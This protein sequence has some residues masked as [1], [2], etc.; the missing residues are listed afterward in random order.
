MATNRASGDLV[1]IIEKHSRDISR[2]KGRLT[3]LDL[4][5]GGLTGLGGDDH[6]QYLNVARHDADDHSG[7]DYLPLSGGVLSGKLTVN[8]EIQYD[9]ASGYNGHLGYSDGNNYISHD[10]GG[11]TRFRNSSGSEKVRVD[12]SGLY[13]P[14]GR[15]DITGGYIDMGGGEIY[16]SG[17]S[18]HYINFNSNYIGIWNGNWALL[19]YNGRTEVRQNLD[20]T[21]FRFYGDTDTSITRPTSNHMDFNAAGLRMRVGA[22]SPTVH[23]KAPYASGQSILHLDI[24]RAWNFLQRGT[25]A[26][27]DLEL[28]SETNKG[29]YIGDQS[30]GVIASF[31]Y[32]EVK[33]QGRD[34]T[35]NSGLA[36]WRNNGF[37]GD[38]FLALSS[39]IQYKANPQDL[40]YAELAETFLD[41]RLADWNSTLPKD[42]P[43]RRYAGWIAEEVQPKLPHYAADPDENGYVSGIGDMTVPMA[44][45]LHYHED[46]I[47]MLETKVAELERKLRSI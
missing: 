30:N 31:H 38:E 4:D 46:R 11:Y 24:E 44:A 5:H 47:Q 1:E 45:T 8:A 39:S 41:I 27:T 16:Y 3:G 40:D 2:L 32:G 42:D 36:A 12:D 22:G 21:A 43:N 17:S 18:G 15:I 25:G 29:F 13:V 37:P 7:L 34:T 9:T 19:G 26:S 14:G 6:P 28:R 33:A 35:T 20:A 23:I 10:A